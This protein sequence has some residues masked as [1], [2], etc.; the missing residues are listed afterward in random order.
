MRARRWFRWSALSLALLWAWGLGCVLWGAGASQAIAQDDLKEAQAAEGRPVEATT[1][2]AS[3]AAAPPAKSELGFLYSALGLKYTVIFLVISF[4]LVALIVMNFLALRRETVCPHA[5]VEG[6]E[7]HLNEKRFQDAYDLAKHNESFLGHV[8]S[9]GLAK[10]SSGYPAAVEAMQAVGEDETMKLE[11][12][13]SYVALIGTI[14]P[15]FGLLGT[16]DG[17]VVSFRVIAESTTQPKPSE[18]ADG[19]SMAL[20]TTLVGLWLAIPAI[21]FFGYFRNRLARLVFDAA[22]ISEQLMSRFAVPAKKP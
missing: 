14:A 7:A 5:L 21:L 10:L 19:I 2:D 6:F 22:S 9:A 8:L 15:M 1:G 20:V 11:Q 3:K 4:C 13:L 16:V 18:L 17:M 12:R